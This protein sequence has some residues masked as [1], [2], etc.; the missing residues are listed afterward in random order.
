MEMAYPSFQ[1]RSTEVNSR[2]SSKELRKLRQT[3]M[4]ALRRQCRSRLLSR[5]YIL[6]CLVVSVTPVL[7][8][9]IGCVDHFIYVMDVALP[10]CIV[11]YAEARRMLL[12]SLLSGSAANGRADCS[13][14]RSFKRY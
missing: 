7:G 13:L 1:F 4:I 12:D 14:A 2:C 10:A 11:L 3:R 9:C 8:C 6:R 5:G